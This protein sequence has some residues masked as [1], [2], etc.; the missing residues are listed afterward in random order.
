MQ[1]F[2]LQR[3]EVLFS[4]SCTLQGPREEQSLPSRDTTQLQLQPLTSSMHGTKV[5][6]HSLKLLLSLSS[7]HTLYILSRGAEA[8]TQQMAFLPCQ[9]DSSKVLQRGPLRQDG[10][11]KRRLAFPVNITP[12]ETAASCHT[13]QPS[14]LLTQRNQKSS[15]ALS[16][17]LAPSWETPVT[18]L[19]FIVYTPTSSSF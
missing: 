13:P 19:P 10:R 18:A 15:S 3:D 12:P 4:L 11:Q 5:I 17:R 9:L 2:C 8:G 6:P 16:Q 14:P 1:G 7:K